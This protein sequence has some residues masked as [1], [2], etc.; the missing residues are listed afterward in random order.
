MKNNIFNI[1]FGL[2]MALPIA[3]MVGVIP[4]LINN[5]A[6]QAS[7]AATFW[8]FVIAW[9]SLSW[10]CIEIRRLRKRELDNILITCMALLPLA[11]VAATFGLVEDHGGLVGSIDAIFKNVAGTTTVALGWLGAALA[12]ARR[13]KVAAA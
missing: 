11:A 3:L 4:M 5:Q 1:F 7:S 8:T 12:Y 9:P 10:R 6:Y 2:A 13:S